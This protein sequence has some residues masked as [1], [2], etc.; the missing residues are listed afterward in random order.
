MQVLP[1]QS[2]FGHLWSGHFREMN[3]SFPFIYVLNKRKSTEC[4]RSIWQKL[5]A[6]APR[7]RNTIKG[8]TTDF[9]ITALNVIESELPDCKRSGCLT[10]FK[11]ARL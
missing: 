4:Y 7:L 9:E 1:R 2:H 5:F 6:I 3:Y 10:H 8:M 11:W